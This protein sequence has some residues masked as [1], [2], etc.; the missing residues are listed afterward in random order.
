MQLQSD[1]AHQRIAKHSLP[2]VPDL[3]AAGI[4]IALFVVCAL[5][6]RQMFGPSTSLTTGSISLSPWA[7]ANYALRT[8]LRMLI[9]LGMSL[10]FTLIYATLSAKRQASGNG[11]D[12]V[13]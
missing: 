2:T 5:G 11:A 10:V 7:L 9:A 12:T 3:I 6:L 8:T 4:I 1:T 13:A